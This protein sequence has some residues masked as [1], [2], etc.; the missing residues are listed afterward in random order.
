MTCRDD[1]HAPRREV[2][3]SRQRGPIAPVPEL[4]ERL[5]RAELAAGSLVELVIGVGERQL[6]DHGHDE[7]VCRD[8]PRLVGDDTNLH[9]RPPMGAQRCCP[10]ERTVA[11]DC[12]PVYRRA[13]GSRTGYSGSGVPC[14][15]CCWR[16]MAAPILP[17]ACSIEITAWFSPPCAISDMIT[18]SA[19]VSAGSARR[20]ACSPANASPDL[21]RHPALRRE[22][23]LVQLADRGVVGGVAIDPVGQ[24]RDVAGRRELVARGPRL[25]D[26]RVRAVEQRERLLVMR[27][28]ALG[29]G[30]HRLPVVLGQEVREGG[31]VQRLPGEPGPV[32]TQAVRQPV[33]SRQQRLVPVDHVGRQGELRVVAGTGNRPEGVVEPG[34]LTLDRPD[35]PGAGRD[36]RREGADVAG[37][38]RRRGGPRRRRQLVDPVREGLELVGRGVEGRPCRLVVGPRELGAT[39]RS[40][41][42]VHRRHDPGRA[43]RDQRREREPG[44]RERDGPEDGAD[45]HGAER[46]RY[47]SCVAQRQPERAR[48]RLPSGG[49]RTRTP[50]VPSPAVRC[51]RT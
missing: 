9:G 12:G 36:R 21:V 24:R 5:E 14:F 6:P 25:G 15:S 28:R 50:S 19:R 49:A 45:I 22:Q 13:A 30:G 29:D 2:A 1:Q 42:V 16:S 8:V 47:G 34:G 26:R 23:R 39:V 32:T 46:S 4:A 48:G 27:R 17:R 35:L 43:E 11:G 20:A 37:V 7:D 33:G 40:R 51:C 44:D 18:T 10:V 31:G 3:G 41:D 38:D